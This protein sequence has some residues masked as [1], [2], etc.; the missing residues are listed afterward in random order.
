MCRRKNDFTQ[1]QR[2]GIG[3]ARYNV[4]M[5]SIAQPDLRH[6][7]LS[8]AKKSNYKVELGRLMVTVCK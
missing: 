1:G 7:D 2:F 8:D 3:I 4:R 5:R 6:L